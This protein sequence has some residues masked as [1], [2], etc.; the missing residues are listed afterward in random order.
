MPNKFGLFRKYNTIGLP[1]HDPEEHVTLEALSDID[2]PAQPVSNDSLYP[3]RNLNAFRLDDWYWN[4]GTQKSLASFQALLDI[5]GDPTFV[6][7]DVRD[8]SWKDIHHKLALNEE[9]VDEDAGWDRTPVTVTVPFQPR[10]GVVSE[11]GAGPTHFTVADF[12][13]RNLISIIR[14]KLSRRA[15]DDFFHYEPYRL[16]WQTPASPTPINVYG[17]LYTSE[18]FVEANHDLQNSPREPDCDAPRHIVGLMFAS[19]ATHLT[20]FGDASL[21]PLYLFFG[22]ESK[23]RRCKPTCHLA[24]HVA[25]F[26][27]V[28]S[29][30]CVLACPNGC[31]TAPRCFQRIRR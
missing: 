26:Q 31:W 6:P 25:Y 28:N 24:N 13:H 11:S 19:D 7:A 5:I 27:K 30:L 29:F 15:D 22:N 2:E 4:G 21:W 16:Q 14:E 9:W 17:E 1:A 18:A 23:Y 3:F 12:Y 8:T 10:R 20:S